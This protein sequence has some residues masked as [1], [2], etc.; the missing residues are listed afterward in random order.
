MFLCQFLCTKI[1]FLILKTSEFFGEKASWIFPCWNRDG[2]VLKFA[3]VFYRTTYRGMVKKWN[4]RLLK[5]LSRNTW[6]KVVPQRNSWDRARSVRSNFITLLRVFSFNYSWQWSCRKI[7]VS[8]SYANWR[9]K[10]KSDSNEKLVRQL[11]FL[12]LPV[13]TFTS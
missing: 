1:W 10:W 6:Q 7:S 9:N 2:F 11:K 12:E 8:S 4:R 3:T 13:Q 5:C